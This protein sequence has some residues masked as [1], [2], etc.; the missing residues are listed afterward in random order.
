MILDFSSLTSFILLKACCLHSLLRSFWIVTWSMVKGWAWNPFII[1]VIICCSCLNNFFIG[2]L[3]TPFAC[4]VKWYFCQFR[5]CSLS[6]VKSFSD[7]FWIYIITYV[8]IENWKQEKATG[9]LQRPWKRTWRKLLYQIPRQTLQSV[10][11]V[12]KILGKY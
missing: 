4:N 11:E 12:F 9:W 5:L 2:M 7:N 1:D 6:E 10:I 8:R 3:F